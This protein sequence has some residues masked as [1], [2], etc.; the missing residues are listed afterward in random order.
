MFNGD[1]LIGTTECLP[2]W[3]RLSKSRRRYK[4]VR[5]YYLCHSFEVLK[6][7]TCIQRS[8]PQLLIM[9]FYNVRKGLICGFCTPIELVSVPKY[10]IC[11]FHCRNDWKDIFKLDMRKYPIKCVE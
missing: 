3:A 4:P 7:T 11:R 8:V 9:Q 6:S 10:F 5:L 1:E 2:L